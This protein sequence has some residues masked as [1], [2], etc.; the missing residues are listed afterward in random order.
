MT[1]ITPTLDIKAQVVRDAILL[2]ANT[3]SNARV[4]QAATMLVAQMTDDEARKLGRL[5]R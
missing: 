2:I 4:L 3:T 5:L 1:P